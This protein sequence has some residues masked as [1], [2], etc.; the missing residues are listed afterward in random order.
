MSKPSGLINSTLIKFR[1]GKKRNIAVNRVS[2]DSSIT[3]V[4]RGTSVDTC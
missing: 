2:L 3:S 4:I 1:T